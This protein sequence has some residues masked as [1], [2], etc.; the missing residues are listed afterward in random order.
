MKY[1]PDLPDS[2]VERV[3][4]L[5]M[6]VEALEASHATHKNETK[7]MIEITNLFNWLPGSPRFFVFFILTVI[8]LSSLTAEI[9][10]KTTGSDLRIRR[11]L[12]DI[13]EIREKR[14]SD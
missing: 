6:K 10:L 8:F 12:I 13:L 9:L 2:F 7:R 4:V 5:E 3:R 1:I 11:H 14:V